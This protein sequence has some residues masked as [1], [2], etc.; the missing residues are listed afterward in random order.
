MS[1][2]WTAKCWMGSSSGYVDIEVSASTI[3]GA[4][5][6]LQRIYGAEQIINLREIRSHDSH[7]SN[8]ST[9]MEGTLAFLAVVAGLIFL[10]SFWPFILGGAIIWAIYKIYKAVK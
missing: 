9:D 3:N 1:R 4:K 2:Q 7:G 8:S 5:E 6:Q 10:V